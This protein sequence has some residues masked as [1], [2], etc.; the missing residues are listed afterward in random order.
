M[1]SVRENAARYAAVGAELDDAPDYASADATRVA[2]VRPP[3]EDKALIPVPVGMDWALFS[4]VLALMAMGVIMAYSASVYLGLQAGNDQHFLQKHLIH[5]GLAL[6]TIMVGAHIPYQWWRR[7]AYPLLFL[8]VGLL[9][10]TLQYGVVVNGSRRWIRLPG[11]MFQTAEF[12][13]VAFVMYLAHSLTKKIEAARVHKFSVGFVPHALAWVAVFALCMKQPDLGTGIVLG[14]LLFAMTFIAG[15][16]MA[17]VVFFGGLAGTGLITFILQNP[18]RRARFFAFLYPEEHRLTTAFQLYNGK[19][20]VA[21]GGLFGNG[22]GLSKQKLGFVPECHTDF[23]LSIIGEELGLIG[24]ALVALAFIFFIRRGLRIALHARDEFGRLLASGITVLFG[25]QAAVNFGVVMGI[26]P[27]KGLTLP[28][29]SHGGSSMLILG[30]ALGILI[31]VGRG[32]NPDA[33]PPSLPSWPSWLRLPKRAAANSP[34]NARS[35]AHRGN[36][37]GLR[38]VDNS[39]GAA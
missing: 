30:M 13:K 23:I 37:A 5:A 6:V 18:M 7:A 36:S 14:V 27:T 31:N 19:L 20:A 11:F 35:G 4:T 16:N 25:T 8:A 10:A 39:G 24:V 2:Q 12:A 3:K 28:F 38:G 34:R 26:L 9:A 1:A 17:Y 22:L 21:T 32:G 33:V 29:V 15:T